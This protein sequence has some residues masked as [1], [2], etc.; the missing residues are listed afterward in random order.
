MK[1]RL[2][3]IVIL[4]SCLGNAQQIEFH[5]DDAGNQVKRGANPC[6]CFL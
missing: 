2:L 1:I 3:F 4:T 6:I 5:Y